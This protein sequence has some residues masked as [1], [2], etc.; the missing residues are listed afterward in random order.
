[1]SDATAAWWRK[2]KAPLRL[3]GSWLGN[4]AI[5]YMPRRCHYRHFHLRW[6]EEGAII[7]AMMLIWD[8]FISLR[9][10]ERKCLQIDATPIYVALPAFSAFSRRLPFLACR[11]AIFARAYRIYGFR[12]KMPWLFD[13]G[14][15]LAFSTSLHII[16]NMPL[17]QISSVS[18]VQHVLL[19][20]AA[21]SSLDIQQFWSRRPIPPQ[22]YMGFA[23]LWRCTGMEPISL[24]EISP[25]QPAADFL[26]I[27]LRL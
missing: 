5:L 3:D 2:R 8:A 14:Y 7:I 10:R 13:I 18:S 12:F 23:F 19:K 26:V 21:S 24:L 9:D 17:L 16:T 20:N 15:W 27:S 22:K 25:S 11:R 4:V 6:F 1:M